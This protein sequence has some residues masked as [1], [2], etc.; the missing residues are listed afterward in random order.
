M[1]VLTPESTIMNTTEE[2]TEYM[3]S[4]SPAA[5]LMTPIITAIT[6]HTRIAISRLPVAFPTSTSSV[7]YRPTCLP[8]LTSILPRE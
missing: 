4:S 3:C 5:P 6:R 1:M 7:E 8:M 2:I